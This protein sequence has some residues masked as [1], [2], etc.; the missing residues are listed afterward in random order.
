MQ[1]ASAEE[2]RIIKY[3]EMISNKRVQTAV[4]ISQ[5]ESAL[6]PANYNSNY[7]C[8]TTDFMSETKDL[9]PSGTQIELENFTRPQGSFVEREQAV[10]VLEKSM[11]TRLFTVDGQ[12]NLFK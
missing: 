5:N 1:S 12:N 10:I 11:I 4:C 6:S 2:Y 9:H 3:F 7:N 8:T